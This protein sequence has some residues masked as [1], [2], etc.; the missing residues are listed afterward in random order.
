VVEG[1][2][3][4]FHYAGVFGEGDGGRGLLGKPVSC[5]NVM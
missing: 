5:S 4:G 1:E 3:V 2:R